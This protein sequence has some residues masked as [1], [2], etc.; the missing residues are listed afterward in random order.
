MSKVKNFSCF[1]D[2]DSFGNPRGSMAEVKSSVKIYAKDSVEEFLSHNKG[3]RPLTDEEIE[4]DAQS[5]DYSD[6][7]NLWLGGNR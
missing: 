7:Y 2:K 5:K 6:L 3:R 4:S 1:I